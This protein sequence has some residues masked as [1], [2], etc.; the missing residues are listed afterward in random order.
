MDQQIPKPFRIVAYIGHQAFGNFLI[1]HVSLAALAQSI[2]GSVLGVL[3]RNDRPYKDFI[4]SLNPSV[5][6]T[7]TLPEDPGYVFPMESL[8][9]GSTALGEKWCALGLNSPDLFL[10]T[11]TLPPDLH[12]LNG[13]MPV[14]G[15]PDGLVAPLS[16]SLIK[17]GV[18]PN[19]WFVGLHMREA[20]YKYRPTLLN[21]RDVDPL[22]YMDMIKMIINEQGGQVVRL[23]DPS[24]KPLPEMD[25]LIDLSRF[26]DNFAEQLFA[27]SRARYFIGC[28]SGPLSFA[29]ATNVPAARVNS[30]GVSIGG[31]RHERVLPKRG[32]VLQDGS[33]L[34]YDQVDTLTADNLPVSTLDNTP[35]QLCEVADYFH[36]TSHDCPGWRD[37][38]VDLPEA[39]P[40]PEFSGIEAP[41]KWTHGDN[42]GRI[43]ETKSG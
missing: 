29:K 21:Y 16:A 23:G 42:M 32:F 9:D 22:S 15:V 27:A 30:M 24:M 38:H 26:D 7:V 11:W 8:I 35:E 2:P 41:I 39:P 36:S 3:Y 20:N 40:D 13:E 12:T 17:H 33:V 37:N 25:G 5:A 18:D 6:A 14:F 31:S 10:T 1:N 43:F 19:N 34:K 28:D 4:T